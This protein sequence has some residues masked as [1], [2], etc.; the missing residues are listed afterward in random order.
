[1][2]LR[3][4]LLCLGAAILLHTSDAQIKDLWTHRGFY[5]LDQYQGTIESQQD[6]KDVPCWSSCFNTDDTPDIDYLKAAYNDIFRA[7][8]EAMRLALMYS[9][10]GTAYLFD[11]T[12]SS[13]HSY[14][15]ALKMEERG[16]RIFKFQKNLAIVVNT[17]LGHEDDHNPAYAIQFDD[18]KAWSCQA[19]QC[20]DRCQMIQNI[21]YLECVHTDG[22]SYHDNKIEPGCRLADDIMHDN[23]DDAAYCSFYLENEMAIAFVNSDF[24]HNVLRVQHDHGHHRANH[25]SACQSHFKTRLVIGTH[26]VDE[27]EMDDW[28]SPDAHY[29][30]IRD[31]SYTMEAAEKLA[32]CMR[33][34]CCDPDY[35]FF[36]GDKHY[37]P[38][39]YGEECWQMTEDYSLEKS[40]Y[41]VH[42]DIR[43]NEES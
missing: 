19:W 12:L 28:Q 1:M 41:T 17:M 4:P 32:D 40:S 23:E 3:L 10:N 11:S 36:H 35:D 29:I 6:N 34:S 14:S 38:N 24:D 37:H 9:V 22:T 16:T 7:G 26:A 13:Y 15:S 39:N 5:D 25:Y 20:A 21:G 43:G 30:Y 18:E 8:H 31:N 27:H 33:A 42:H 2:T